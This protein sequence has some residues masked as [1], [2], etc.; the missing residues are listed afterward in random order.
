MYNNLNITYN[1][2]LNEM[3]NAFYNECGKSVDN[4][5]DVDMR[6]KAVA[7]EI[8][9]VASFGDYIFKQG[10]PQT[11]SGVHLDRH[12]QLRGITRKKPSFAKGILTFSVSEKHDQDIVIP[13]GTVCASKKLPYIQFVTDCEETIIRDCYNVDVSAT[14]L[15]CGNDYNVE[16]NEITVMV[17]PPQ[18]V[19]S[20]TNKALFTGGF[21]EE[22]D[23]SLR[24][25][26]LSSYNVISNGVN[27]Q[28]I[29]ELLLSVDFVVDAIAFAD[30]NGKLNVCIK[31]P[32]EFLPESTKEE[33]AKLLGFAEFCNVPINFIS[34]KHK[35][36][37]IN[38]EAKIFQGYDTNEIKD[39]IEKRIKRFCN[40]GKI[41]ESISISA[42]ASSLY[43]ID[44]VEYFN[45]YSDIATEGVIN[46][47][48]T[49]FLQLLVI[50][51]D[52]HE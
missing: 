38:V 27:S 15:K 5:S 23:E 28:S 29:R 50:G 43:G 10:F 19:S 40:N 45:V 18:Y 6:F 52:I 12:A 44:G 14:A 46:C 16:E 24:E 11:A 39:E 48:K 49:E 25:R 32:N 51:A 2:V 4:F 31:T 42:I 37:V 34:A 36:F 30:E 17:N 13:K 47:K 26:I 8:F 33:A 9:S 22:S 21:D 7:S 41:G 1:D 20:V 35:S 3:K